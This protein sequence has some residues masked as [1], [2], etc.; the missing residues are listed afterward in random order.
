M[1]VLP[2]DASKKAVL[3]AYSRGTLSRSE[4]MNQLGME[5]YGE[6]LDALSAAGIESPSLPEAELA[7]MVVHATKVLGE[8]QPDIQEAPREGEPR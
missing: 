1:M 8:I 5:W 2:E 7:A 6:L 3:T 4:A